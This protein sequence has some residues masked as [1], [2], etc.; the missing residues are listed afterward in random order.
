MSWNYKSWS[1]KR[2]RKAPNKREKLKKSR[3]KKSSLPSCWYSG[4]WGSI[5]VGIYQECVLTRTRNPIG[6]PARKI[7]WKVDIF[8]TGLSVEKNV[9]C[10]R[11]SEDIP[12]H[13]PIRR[14]RSSY[15]Q[16]I[17]TWIEPQS[18]WWIS[19]VLHMT[20]STLKTEN[21]AIMNLRRSFRCWVRWL[22]L[23]VS[24][25]KL[26]HWFACRCKQAGWCVTE[27][28]NQ[29]H[30]LSGVLDFLALDL[31]SVRV[32]PLPNKSR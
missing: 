22:K 10:L 27:L 28:D 26:H 15:S 31:M 9:D 2:A 21:P 17:P 7:P 5:W 13:E 12:L 4:H 1:Q 16:H 3:H 20:K 29:L 19:P 30:R 6:N 25:R 24:I 8:H 23:V 14:L 11:Y 32:L 18:H